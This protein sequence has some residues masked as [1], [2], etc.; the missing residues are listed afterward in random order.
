MGPEKVKK[1]L[2]GQ[3]YSG[4]HALEA[5]IN[6]YTKVNSSEDPKADLEEGESIAALEV[7]RIGVD[8]REE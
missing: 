2:L 3:K 5:E 1:Q 6:Y 8:T 7:C 4:T